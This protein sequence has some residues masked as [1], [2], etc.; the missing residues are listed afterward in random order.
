MNE[1]KNKKE[2]KL[3]CPGIAMGIYNYSIV[4][5]NETLHHG[6]FVINR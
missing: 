6:K 1:N 4:T 5:D 3:Q 2:I